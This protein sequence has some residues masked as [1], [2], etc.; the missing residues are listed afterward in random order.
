M[1]VGKLVQRVEQDDDSALAG[2]IAETLPETIAKAVEVA[3]RLFV[4]LLLGSGPFDAAAIE[5]VQ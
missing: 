4:F 3:F 1:P 2:V 5:F